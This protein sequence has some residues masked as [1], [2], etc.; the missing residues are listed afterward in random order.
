MKPGTRR[1]GTQRVRLIVIHGIG[2]QKAGATAARWAD[3]IVRFARA[4]GHG[5]EVTTATLTDDPARVTVRLTPAADARDTAPPTS[6]IEIEEAYWAESFP[7]PTVGRVLRFLLT[8]APV[9]AITQSIL[10][11]RARAQLWPAGTTTPVAPPPPDT[12]AQEG[13][14]PPDTEATPGFDAPAPEGTA[15]PDTT[16]AVVTSRRPTI[17]ATVQATG[18]TFA[19]VGPL[20]LGVL[21]LGLAAPVIAVLLLVLLVASSLPIPAL[22]RTVGKALG[23]LSTSIGDAYLFVAD[24]VNRAAMER[25]LAARLEEKSSVPPSRT[26][27]LAHSQGAALAY[28]SLSGVPLSKRPAAFVTVGSGVGRLHEVGLLQTLPWYLTPLFIAIVATAT[29]GL[30]WGRWGV[31]L[32]LLAVSL[33]LSVLAWWIC[34]RWLDSPRT[35]KGEQAREEE[36]KNRGEELLEPI[37]GMSWLDIW[38]SFDL[39]PNGRTAADTNTRSYQLARVAGEQ[40]IVRDHVR[41]DLDWDQTMPLVFTRL[42]DPSGLARVPY[43]GVRPPAKPNE[44]S[45]EQRI[46]LAVRDWI[47]LALRAVPLGASGWAIAESHSELFRIGHWLQTAPPG[48]LDSTVDTVLVPLRAFSDFLEATWVRAPRPQELLAVIALLVLG[49]AGSVLTRRVLTFFQRRETTQWLLGGGLRSP[50]GAPRWGDE[51]PASRLGRARWPLALVAVAVAAAV[52]PVFLLWAGDHLDRADERRMDWTQ[53]QTVEAYL[54]AVAEDDMHALCEITTADVTARPF[55]VSGSPDPCDSDEPDALDALRTCEDGRKAVAALDE[56]AFTF[57]GPEAVEVI[58]N[59]EDAATCKNR[60]HWL[61]LP[62]QV[63]FEQG[64]WQITGVTDQP[65]E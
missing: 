49:L 4:A 23:F 27:L 24:P 57:T 25:R 3:A 55:G 46:P 30:A 54:T 9:L 64:R 22:R 26:V 11:W 52:V 43:V 40:S 6:E 20:A 51:D 50:D 5:T 15:P 61:A 34:I 59:P 63:A 53:A 2:S 62:T 31:T 13:T 18:H 45:R 42:L 17:R 41:Y 1:V 19:L 39:V 28:R 44:R 48:W 33:G 65:E 37:E 36:R 47:G 16:A 60:D 21:A 32:P 7:E 12:T 35:D 58:W 8:V 38:A 10:V 14:A 29:T 56:D